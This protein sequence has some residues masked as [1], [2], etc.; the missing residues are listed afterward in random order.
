[1]V[2][3]RR[4][5]G[6]VLAVIAAG[7]ALGSAARYGVAQALPHAPG[8]VAW[9]TVVVNVTGAFLLGAVMVLVLEVWPPQRYL[10]PFLGV[11]VLGGYT[12]FS[13]F[14]ADT[15]TMVHEGRAGP[16]AAYA[17][18]SLLVG[19]ASAWGGLAVGRRLAHGSGAGRSGRRRR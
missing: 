18:A 11:G 8:A 19:L 14:M 4:A 1:M 2:R 17:V 15:A 16:A 12:T 7:G 5:N 13:T 3:H 9:S 6:D 10:R